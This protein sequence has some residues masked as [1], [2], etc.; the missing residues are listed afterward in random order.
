[1]RSFE[2]TN[3]T[4]VNTL[5]GGSYADENKINYFSGVCNG[6]LG[7]LL[8]GPLVASGKVEIA[9]ISLPVAQHSWAYYLKG[10]AGDSVS[11]LDIRPK[12][13]KA[14]DIYLAKYELTLPSG[15]WAFS[16]ELPWGRG[17]ASSTADIVATLRCLDAV[18]GRKSEPAA[19]AP[20]LREI[21][22]S[23]SV[24]LDGY[25][26]YLSGCQEVIRQLPGNP[27]FHVCYIDEQRVVN[28]DAVTPALLSNY[29]ENLDAY[30]RN[31][32]E[33]LSA[34][35][36]GDLHSIGRCSTVSAILGQ[37]AVPKRTL[38]PM[39]DHQDI[40][41]ADG[42]VVAHTGS[43]IGYLFKDRPSASRLGALSAFFL[44]MGYQC[45]YSQPRH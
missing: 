24:F 17:M 20:I 32:S 18:F 1:M 7:E 31:L 36:R 23:D 38:Q 29:I 26:L 43:L 2:P 11:E 25:A 42:I 3:T 16:S 4:A 10:Q 40:F 35:D 15:L 14:I 44:S 33:M 30:E 6:T 19:I 5:S 12:C 39:V 34:F 27:A 22:R 45:Q 41:G 9:I 37:K 28:T 21:E 8:Q 13:R